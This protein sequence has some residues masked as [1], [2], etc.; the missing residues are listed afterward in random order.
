MAG[1]IG[2]AHV[3]ERRVEELARRSRL[4]M[5]ETILVLHGDERMVDNPT[6]DF[7]KYLQA[8]R[9]NYHGGYHRCRFWTST[10]STGYRVSTG[11]SHSVDGST[12]GQY[13][14]ESW[15][16]FARQCTLEP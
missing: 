8:A 12:R 14:K 5:A 10:W 3:G 6:A 11:G 9:T 2:A 1:I 13:S 16:E 4:A 15:H 7:V